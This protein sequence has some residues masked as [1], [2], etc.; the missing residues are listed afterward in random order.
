MTNW[1]EKEYTAATCQV[2]GTNV[3][4]CCSNSDAVNA[5]N[6]TKCGAEALIKSCPRCDYH[7][8]AYCKFCMK[9]GAALTI[10]ALMS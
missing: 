6:C 3:N 1:D 2:C 5:S 7:V 8:G 10:E 4:L 9:C